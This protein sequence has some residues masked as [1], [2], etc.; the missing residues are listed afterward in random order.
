M[1]SGQPGRG[2]TRPGRENV[3]RFFV[4]RA[5]IF[6]DL[7]AEPEGIWGQGDKV[8]V[9]VR[10]TGRGKGSG[11]EFDIRIGHVGTLRDGLVVRG[12]G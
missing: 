3:F 12:E 9:F 7:R 1:D 2:G 4:D 5:E 10:T 6:D 8:L 11:A